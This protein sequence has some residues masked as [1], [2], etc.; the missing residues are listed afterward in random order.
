MRAG[1]REDPGVAVA[2]GPAGHRGQPDQLHE[3]LVVGQRRD[4]AL[5][6]SAAATQVARGMPCHGSGWS[7]SR[8]S[9]RPSMSARQPSSRDRVDGAGDG[10]IVADAGLGAE[11][12]RSRTR[13]PRRPAADST[14]RPTTPRHDR[15]RA[16]SRGAGSP[17]RD[18]RRRGSH[19]RPSPRS[20]GRIRPRRSRPRR[21]SRQCRPGTPRRCERA[22]N[23]RS[24]SRNARPAAAWAQPVGGQREPVRPAIA[25]TTS[26]TACRARGAPGRSATSSSAASRPSRQVRRRLRA[27][28]EQ[29]AVDG[30]LVGSELGVGHRAKDERPHALLRGEEF[31]QE[32]EARPGWHEGDATTW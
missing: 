23:R 27:L 1:A 28:V 5:T 8:A 16:R 31:E 12:P 19:V 4:P 21:R 13:A 14:V 7:R 15:H 18:G 9:S 20:I 25:A 24:A 17:G 32:R 10:A 2:A 11:R 26:R 22:V 3:S 6:A 29:D 30:V